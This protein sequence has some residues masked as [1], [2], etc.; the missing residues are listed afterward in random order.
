M[1]ACC[2]GQFKLLILCD[3]PGSANDRPKPSGCTI[4]G[5][6]TKRRKA[7]QPGFANQKS[8]GK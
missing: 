6:G 3:L 8:H 2:Y 5:K 1:Q 4:I 7:V